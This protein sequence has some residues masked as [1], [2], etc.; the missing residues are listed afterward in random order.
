MIAI[1]GDHGGF[2]LKSEVMKHLDGLGLEYKDFGTFSEE[3]TDYPVYGESVGRAVVSG[4]CDRGIIICGTGIGISIAA[5]KVR[6]VRAALCGDC[7]SAEMARA[8]NDANV[9]ALGARVVGTGHALKI[10]DTFLN[11]G[12]EG[13]RHARRVGLFG[14]IERNSY[15]PEANDGDKV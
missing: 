13:G 4:V 10:V 12:F 15:L 5:N 1:G 8:H 7:F 2:G 6:G 3:S 11:T 9:L 14:D